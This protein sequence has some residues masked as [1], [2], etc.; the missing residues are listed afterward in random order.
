MDK[1]QN[2]KIIKDE[3]LLL[4]KKISTDITD[5][6]D[7][8]FEMIKLT[9]KEKL[10]KDGGMPNTVF[11]IK[12]NREFLSIEGVKEDIDALKEAANKLYKEADD[13][14]CFAYAKIGK[15]TFDHDSKYRISQALS[16][17]LINC[18]G[19]VK[20]YVSL[21]EKKGKDI[22]LDEETPAVVALNNVGW[23]NAFIDRDIEVLKSE[24]LSVLISF[25]TNIERK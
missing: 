4:K 25:Y 9:C 5:F 18:L 15:V 16:I 22:R 24:P 17:N 21:V 8:F 2:N 14:I 7:K 12:L 11:A 13:V 3:E 20:N 1:K 6:K 23:K 19:D 10:V